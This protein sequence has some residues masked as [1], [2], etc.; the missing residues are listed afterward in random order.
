[1]KTKA[2]LTGFIAAFICI[3]LNAQVFVGGSLSANL[4][5]SKQDGT[6]SSDAHKSYSLAV[7]P[8]IGKFFSDKIAAGVAVDF[9]YSYHYIQNDPLTID[10]SSE[11]GVTP[12]VRYYALKWNKF[13]VY[14]Q[15]NLFFG[16][17][18]LSEEVNN[19]KTY[20]PKGME[21]SLY[22]FP[23]L[24]YDI[25]EKLSLQAGL[26]FMSFGYT[27]YHNKDNGTTTSTSV[28]GLSGDLNNITT[29]GSIKIGAIYKF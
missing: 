27:Y 2:I 17:S 11:Y 9:E 26:S 12:F 13:S 18:S 7:S 23:G 3:S 16:Y 1:M 20:G 28:F 6:A 5:K 10:K 15:G 24:S 22:V 14:G 25:S 19:I 8:V 29:L 21:I 4:V